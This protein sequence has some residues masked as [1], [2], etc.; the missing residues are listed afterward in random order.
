MMTQAARRSACRRLSLLL[1]PVC[2]L[3]VSVRPLHAEG[4]TWPPLGSL[5]GGTPVQVELQGTF[6]Y[7]AAGAAL[8]VVDIS[9]PSKPR[10]VAYC[11]TPGSAVDIAV[12]GTYAYVADEWDGLAV[13]NIA[14]PSH[15]ALV[16]Q[17]DTGDMYSVAVA[18]TKAYLID[19]D[20]GLIVVD[21]SDPSNPLE[22]GSLPLY[23]R[24]V[25]VTG[26]YAYV[27]GSPGLRVISIE[28]PSHPVEVGSISLTGSAND[29]AI[30]GGY[31][32]V[33][34]T[35]AGLRVVDISDPRAPVEVGHCE[36]VYGWSVALG[37][38]YAYVAGSD[39]ALGV[40]DVSDPAHP[41]LVGVCDTAGS[42][43][44]VAVAAPYAYVADG[45]GGLRVVDVSNP[46]AP[47]E[48]SRLETWGWIWDVAGAGDYAYA[49]GHDRFQ[50]LDVSDP[51]NPAPIGA[52]S[53]P[54]IWAVAVSSG[55]A[56]LA[57]GYDG[58]KVLSLA[59]PANPVPVAQWD[60]GPVN[61]PWATLVAVSGNRALVG[62][63]WDVFVADISDP[64]HPIRSGYGTSWGVLG[65]ALDGRYAYYAWKSIGH[66]WFGIY[67]VTTGAQ[68]ALID[69]VWEPRK[70]AVSRGYA[71]VAGGYRF[72]MWVFNVWN[73][74]NPILVG[75]IPTGGAAYD[76]AVSGS[77]AYVG[78][79]YTGLHV[80]DVSVPASPVEVGYWNTPGYTY[81]V[82]VNSG[83]VYVRDTW[84]V[85]I[86]PEAAAT[87]TGRVR[88]TGSGAGI[89]GATV[90][91]YRAGRP[92]GSAVS[93][94]AGNYRIEGLAAADYSVT[95]SQRNCT[96]QTQTG[97]SLAF[98]QT[99]TVNFELDALKAT[100][101]GQA[102]ARA[103]NAALANA[104]VTAFV[105][106]QPVGTATTDSVGMYLIETTTY[107]TQYVLSCAHAGY[108]T[109]TKS[110]ITV[111]AGQTSGVNFFLDA[112][113]RLKGQV[114]SA[115]TGA[116]LVGARVSVYN[117]ASL[118]TYTLTQAPYGIYRFETSQ[119]AA[120][121]YQVVAS[122]SGYL[123]QE[124][125]NVTVNGGA[126]T[127]LNFKLTPGVTPAIRGQ[128]VDK[129]TGAPLIGAD[130]RVYEYYD[131]V[132][133]VN[134]TAPW[135]MYAVDTLPG[136][137][138]WA[139]ASAPGY[140]EQRRNGIYVIPG[141]T[142]YANFFLSPQ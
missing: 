133:W 136:G 45:Y 18:G 93:D 19:R 78:D 76:V 44:G 17:L 62:G 109:Q 3:L 101:M 100:I 97:I 4:G 42:S 52:Y 126:T 117:G 34:D 12:S 84:G 123:P 54:E 10:Q 79:Y 8:T 47:A 99:A 86:F 22:V 56:Y 75:Y 96:S 135:G 26:S 92:L 15:P 103:T 137:I 27:A 118:V 87:L 112:A 129:V 115:A 14:D 41:S 31:A 55:Y 16:G 80:I 24:G 67:D 104:T 48:A 95:A 113:A 120:G 6:A 74:A 141:L 85:T 53:S 121:T 110:P 2:F 20:R 83:R 50:T 71:Y 128:V 131:L 30:S 70:I 32:Y 66:R 140:V 39:A 98:G 60:P 38:A 89:A 124:K 61:F 36:N 82:R 57:C 106:G 49:V 105:G 13:V 119:L 125:W 108:E 28:D 46:A 21:V 90:A 23:G 114:R 58:L 1:F 37:G 77:Y 5:G 127:F 81:V 91:A 139:K 73:P 43:A 11:D 111:A 130:V 122:L 72:G 138:S 59:N 7:V 29:V 9:D 40:V 132:A 64:A 69:R 63:G 88:L 25:A 142:A 68:L 94:A 65:M 134:T 33:A 102:R 107:S 35:Y 116:A 51:A